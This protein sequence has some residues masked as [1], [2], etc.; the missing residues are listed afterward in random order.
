MRKILIACLA[1]AV[2]PSLVFAGENTL[3]NTDIFQLEYAASPQISPDGSR[4][5]YARKSMDI[6]SD[7]AVSNIWIIDADGGKHRPLLSGSTSYSSPRWSPGGDRLAY[8]SGDGNRGAQIHVRWMDSGQTAV[9]SNLRHTP[10][11]LSWSPDGKQIAFTMFV[12]REATS[13]AK[14]PAKPE[15]AEWAP[16]VKVIDA[17]QYRGDGAGYLSTGESHIFVISAEG[18]T[19]RQMTNGEFNHGGRLSWTPDGDEIIFAAN[20]QVDYEYDPVESEIWALDV[21]SAELSP[22]T[23]RNGPDFAPAV[24]PDGRKIAY[25]GFDDRKMGY[26]NVDV[27]ILDRESNTVSA[28]TTELDREVDD[29]QWAGSSSRLYVSYDDFGRKLLASLSLGGEVKVVANDVGGT[30]LGRPYTS[31]GFSTANNGAFAYTAG[32]VHRPADVASGRGTRA[33]R[34]L[35]SLN[36]DL[37]GRKQLG[38]V[39]EISWKSSAGDLQIQGWIVTPPGFDAT[40]KYPLILEIHGGPFATYGPH[41][42]SEVQLYAAA[43]YVVL[44]TNPR[45]STSYGF[46]FANEIHHNYPGQDYDDL[47]SGVDAVVALG[48]IDEEQLF[49]TGGSGGGVLSAWIVGKTD[50]F[51]AAVV[52]KPVINW[53]STVLTTDIAT[54][55]PEYWFADMPWED[56]NAY[57]VRSPL[58]LVGNVT[59]PTA[60]LTGEQ[61]HRTPIPESEQYYQALK[62]RKIDTA[63]IRVPEASHGI[64]ARPSHLI[65]KIDNILAWFE[66]YK[67]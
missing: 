33:T 63:L 21:E 35:T 38:A 20:L 55:M 43:G 3:V 37:F 27:Y 41:F 61:D 16:P 30:T 29:V 49:V 19:P 45:G 53:T 66:R 32:T 59:T 4:V 40:Q 65:A 52:A 28:L 24:S 7:R 8:V 15:G 25:L 1:A 44:Y 48:Y 54:F 31:G 60:L 51:A 47:M 36:D 18:G 11:S 64:A 23:D 26:H 6:M 62:L 56:P 22:L 46:D 14:P 58:S 39:E 13:L 12:P 42:S 17:I 9:I 2:I 10:S 67:K 5:A 34:R 57:W 50:R